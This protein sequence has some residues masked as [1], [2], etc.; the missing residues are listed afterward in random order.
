MKDWKGVLLI[1]MMLIAFTQANAQWQLG[2]KGGINI[3]E[4]VQDVSNVQG[5]YSVPMALGQ[6]GLLVNY[7]F[8]EHFALQTELL[9]A[10]KG[11]MIY[12]KADKSQTWILTTDWW[13]LTNNYLQVPMMVQGIVPLNKRFSM[14]ASAG[15][16]GAYWLS[17]EWMGRL[18][19]QG[20]GGSGRSEPY[21]FDEDWGINQRKD[22]RWEVGL[23]LG[24]GITASV[25]KGT[26]AAEAR[27]EQGL[28]DLH[29][30]NGSRPISY[31]GKKNR[32]YAFTLAYLYP[33]GSS[34]KMVKGLETAY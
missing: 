24:A 30:F 33:L 19:G 4:V 26:L 12:R 21:V 5:A 9:Y 29:Q 34:R 7:R 10:Q 27:F 13:A 22:N 6:G 25:W 20:F 14:F 32:V 16:Y 2:I 28:S 11:Y 8:N 17:G 18:V 31:S 1:G 3:A 23:S 15:A